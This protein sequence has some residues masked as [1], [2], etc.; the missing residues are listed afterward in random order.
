MA[1]P[2]YYELEFARTSLD[3][4]LAVIARTVPP[5]SSV[6]DLGCNDGRISQT[7]LRLGLA[8]H[9]LGVDICDLVRDPLPGF[10][11]ERADLLSLETFAFEPVDAVLLLNILHHVVAES[12][13][14]ARALVDHLL[15]ISPLVLCDMG[16]FSEIGAWPWRRQFER[17]W[18]SDSEMWLDLFA[19]ATL[20]MPLL[21]YRAQVGGRR[22]LWRLGADPGSA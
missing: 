21:E 18:C 3:L 1:N 12:R 19:S 22:V 14:R 8:R 20:R 16:S 7:L 11:F 2:D 5:D 4:R 6:L 17:Y 15:A 10:T 9:V 13:A